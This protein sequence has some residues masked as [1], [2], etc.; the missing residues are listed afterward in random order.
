MDTVTISRKQYDG[1]IED[2][3]TLRNLE[4]SGL[5]LYKTVKQQRMY[6]CTGKLDDDDLDD[7]PEELPTP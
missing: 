2:Q 7:D 3:K 6:D 4:K 5:V 1:L